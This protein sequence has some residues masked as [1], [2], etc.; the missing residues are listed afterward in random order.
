MT[1]AERQ[2]VLSLVTVPG[3]QPAMEPADF[4][5]QFGAPDGQELTHRVLREAVDRRDPIDVE[6]GLILADVFGVSDELLPLLLTLAAADWHRTHEDVVTILG[7][8][9]NPEAVEA[10]MGAAHWVP[11]YL[12]FDESRAL[13]IKAVRALGA[14]PGQR[15][16]NALAQLSES[17]IEPVRA[18]ASAQLERRREV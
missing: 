11:R 9:R 4:L 8:L 16:E 5:H 6:M 15:A 7:R 13:A 10:L 12:D 18:V 2:L 1:P 17:E 14:I 3:Q